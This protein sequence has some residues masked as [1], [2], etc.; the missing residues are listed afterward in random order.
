MVKRLHD[1]SAVLQNRDDSHRFAFM[2]YVHESA[3]MPAALGAGAGV[4]DHDNVVLWRQLKNLREESPVTSNASRE[5]VSNFVEQLA[6]LKR[7]TPD[8]TAH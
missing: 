2:D 3:A 7:D 1:Q 5:K 6:E 8:L 4:G